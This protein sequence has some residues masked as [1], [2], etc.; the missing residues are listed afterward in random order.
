MKNRRKLSILL[1]IG[2]LVGVVVIGF[3]TLLGGK[4]SQTFGT[5]N[6]GL[7]DGS[8]PELGGGAR[9]VMEQS[10]S[11]SAGKAAPPP[12]AP[13]DGADMAEVEEEMAAEDMADEEMAAE[14]EM[15]VED[16]AEA[17]LPAKG[18]DTGSPP[19]THGGAPML[20]GPDSPVAASTAVARADDSAEAEETDSDAAEADIPQPQPSPAPTEERI[21]EEPR[22]EDWTVWK[23]FTLAQEDN[24][25][26]FA[27]DVDTASYTA[28]RGYLEN[29]VVPPPASIRIE[30]FVNFFDYDYPK[31]TDHALGINN[32][33]SVSP[34]MPDDVPTSYLARIGIQGKEVTP[35]ERDDAVLTFV[36]DVSGSMDVPNRLPLVKE[37]LKL[38]VEQLRETDKVGI[39]IYGDRGQVVLEHT[40]VANRDSILKAID[41]VQ[42][43]GSTNME[44]GLWL[45][46]EEAVR[47][48]NPE[49]INRVIL[50]SDG[51]ANVG[52]STPE[53]LLQTIRDYTEQ[54]IYLSTIGFGMGDFNDRLME[55]I[56]DNGNGNYAYVDTLDEAKRIFV[57][58]LTS[59]LQVIAKDA[60]I[61]VEFNPQAVHS[62]RLL[63]YENRDIA[64][65][66][67]R[68]DTVDAGEV[69]AGHSVTALY[70]LVLTDEPQGELFKTQIRYADPDTDE[71]YEYSQP[72][73]VADIEESFDDAPANFQLA[74]AV[75][76]FA[77]ELRAYDP[78]AQQPFAQIRETVERLPEPYQSDDDVAE[79]EQ[80]LRSAEQGLR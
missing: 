3:S 33:V 79:L 37:S 2:I 19:P 26:T 43:R 80:L 78:D 46:Y 73:L 56:A 48:L 17:G 66:Q 53:E 76:A 32:E 10:Q 12:A 45:G 4:V 22:E 11:G 52:A 6:Q 42:N 55:Q 38:L 61:Q 27:M 70:E 28:A 30:E 16:M 54:G 39:I 13:A 62:Y 31:P 34:W 74:A 75:A 58:R 7:G 1:V 59:T 69:G 36:I 5:I 24:L 50:C 29:G 15:A 71:V 20:A 63:G 40:A 47:N 68:D 64:D 44:E 57:E 35:Q 23:P 72:F 67:F 21:P 18:P 65:E 25:S 41:S 9:S 60:K 77:W 8:A 49:G 14:E 51:V